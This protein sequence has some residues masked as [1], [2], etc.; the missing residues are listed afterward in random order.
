VPL[1]R[2]EPLHREYYFTLASRL[3]SSAH[4]WLLDR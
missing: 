1:D 2:G 4:G 3:G